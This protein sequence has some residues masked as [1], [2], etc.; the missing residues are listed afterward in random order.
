MEV[1]NTANDFV[2]DILLHPRL[3][4]ASLLFLVVVVI[5]II[6]LVKLQAWNP[7]AFKYKLEQARENARV[8]Y[9][10]CQ[11][12]FF[13]QK[14]LLKDLMAMSNFRGQVKKTWQFV[15]SF[16][17]WVKGNEIWS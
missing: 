14:W 5:A 2:W 7:L 1:T 16:D 12:F 8:R 15:I 17:T 13:I 3:K 4:S 6:L 10:L 11:K 9:S